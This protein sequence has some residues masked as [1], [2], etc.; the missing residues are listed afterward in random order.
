MRACRTQSAG[1][2]R[3][4]A[5]RRTWASSVESRAGRAVSNLGRG[6]LLPPAR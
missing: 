4:R 5:R 6:H 2:C 1:A 3:L